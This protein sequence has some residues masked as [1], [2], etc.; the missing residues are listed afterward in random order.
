MEKDQD[1][2]PAWTERDLVSNKKK[3]KNKKKNK[4]SSFLAMPFRGTCMN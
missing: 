1:H 2:G 3:K 4:K